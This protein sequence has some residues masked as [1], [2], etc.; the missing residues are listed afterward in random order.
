MG[1]L[2]SSNPT[3]LL[4]L[5]PHG[6]PHPLPAPHGALDVL[7]HRP[8]VRG[9][10]GAFVPAPLAEAARHLIIRGIADITFLCACAN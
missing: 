9:A 8:I 1:V 7:M 5:A 6:A 10:P 4:F 2:P 3:L